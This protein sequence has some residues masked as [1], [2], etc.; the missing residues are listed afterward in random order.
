MK[1][2][3]LN[4]VS[5]KLASAIRTMKD[6]EEWNM[7]KSGIAEAYS[8]IVEAMEDN[9]KDFK[10]MQRYIGILTILNCYQDYLDLFHEEANRE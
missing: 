2:V 9:S 4:C 10:Q 7:A 3:K 5:E 8:L 1:K 6:E